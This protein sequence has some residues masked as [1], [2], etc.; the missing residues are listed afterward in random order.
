[1]TP[2]P[3]QDKPAGKVKLS[4]AMAIA[5]NAMIIWVGDEPHYRTHKDIPQQ[6]P[7]KV[8]RTVKKARAL[9]KESSK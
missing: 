5:L 4:R 8:A 6:M 3:A 1:M 9:V 7:S 2:H